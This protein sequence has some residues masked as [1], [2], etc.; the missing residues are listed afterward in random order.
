MTLLL[1]TDVLIDVALDREPFVE[2]AAALLTALEARP[3][4]GRIAWHTA[5]NFYYLVAPAR[6][7]R[8]TRRFL[9][10]LVAFVP[11]A[12]TSTESLRLAI[13]LELE[14]FEDAMQVAAAMACGAE[15]IITRNLK[16]Y[17]ASPVSARRPEEALAQLVG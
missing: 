7:R 3:G 9:A 13:G 10:E 17:Q 14:D 12:E 1:D 6:G 4:F 11:V 8:D 16:D 15:T 5:S 2:P